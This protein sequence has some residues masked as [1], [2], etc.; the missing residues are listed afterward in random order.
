[1]Y[2]G[3]S[4]SSSVNLFEINSSMQVNPSSFTFNSSNQY[5]STNT[6][7]E[8]LSKDGKILYKF[9]GKCSNTKYTVPSTV[10]TI[11]SNAMISNNNLIEL[12]IPLNVIKI[13]W[14][15]IRYF[16]KL[17]FLEIS[18]ECQDSIVSDCTSLESVICNENVTKAL[19]YFL[20]NCVNF[21]SL[22][23]KATIPPTINTNRFL[24]RVTKVNIYVPDS[25]VEVYKSANSFVNFVDRIKPVSERPSA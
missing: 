19:T 18:G 1:M 20:N 7:L 13:E 4:L 16:S 5:F 24:Y 23:F 12:I 21:T 11:K 10:E 6:G 15:N 2:I 22:E 8:V 9:A 14:S 17:K 25:S 3:A